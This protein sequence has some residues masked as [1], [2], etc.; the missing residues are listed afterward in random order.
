MQSKSNFCLLNLDFDCHCFL[1][2]ANKQ[3]SNSRL[4]YPETTVVFHR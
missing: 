2:Q 3:L 1:S 4:N